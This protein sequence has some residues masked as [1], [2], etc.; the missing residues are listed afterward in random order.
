M[1]TRATSVFLCFIV[2][3][4]DCYAGVDLH[5]R[6]L[7]S[8]VQQAIDGY[9]GDWATWGSC[10]ESCGTHG[11]RL[12]TRACDN[13]VPKN[14]GK[15]CSGADSEMSPC[16]SPCPV[17]G[18]WGSWNAMKL[19][20]VT[21]GNGTEE[22]ARSC[23]NPAPAHGGKQCSGPSVKVSPCSPSPCA[24]DG[25]WGK[26]S[27]WSA[28]SVS[29]GNG[30]EYR[31]RRC[32]HPSPSHGGRACSGSSAQTQSC[33]LNA[34]PVNGGWSHWSAWG[35]CSVTC[36]DGVQ[37]RT[38][39]CSNPAPS[40][41]GHGCIGA[42]QG[43]Q[44]CHNNPCPVNG[45]WG[46]WSAWGHCSVTCNDGVQHR[47]RTCSNPAP[48]HG[49]HGCIGATQG[50]QSCH[51]NPCCHDKMPQNICVAIWYT[52]RCIEIVGRVECAKTCIY[53]H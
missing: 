27:H 10:S 20:S 50:S 3:A 11:Y 45:G 30:A 18:H 38:R 32:D 53:C 48:S 4:S 44:S 42:T 34:C 39:T 29:C 9:W 7:L 19:C 24:I 8:S 43:S 15:P 31:H 51:N 12:R 37:H 49:G 23:D 47:T 5:P 14:G 33:H 1:E 13:P 40:H 16:F 2:I 25:N 26:W 28:C 36:N 35:H 52:G 21:C 6:F 22:Y 41:G 17:D 46:H